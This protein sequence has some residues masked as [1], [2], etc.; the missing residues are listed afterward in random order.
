MS[1]SP[2][3]GTTKRFR[4]NVRGF[5]GGCEIR[6]RVVEPLV[7][8]LERPEVHRD[9]DA[10]LKIEVDANRLLGVHVDGRHEPARLV[11]ANRDQ[12]EIDRA[13]PGA[14]LGEVAAVARIT[15]EIDRLPSDPDAEASPQRS[16]PV[17]QAASREVLGR[18]ARNRDVPDALVRPPIEL[19]HASQA[20]A[21]E[22]ARISKRRDERRSEPR[23]ELAERL[24]LHVVVVIV[25]HEDDID[26]RQL[27]DGVCRRSNATRTKA[28]ERSCVTREH[29]IREDRRPPGLDQKC[30]MADERRCDA[31]LRRTHRQRLALDP[32]AR[33]PATRASRGCATT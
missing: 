3:R 20:D 29:R 12:R 28:P 17:A 5:P 6:D 19:G 18:R 32:P 7:R 8:E 21:M 13:Q 11:G 2:K 10:R 14:D 24:G 31:A 25:T 16:I 27:R 26:R 4:S 33:M 15:R 22:E 30:R 9:A 1:V 23:I